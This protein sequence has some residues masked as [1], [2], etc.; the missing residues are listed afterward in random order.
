MY[1]V[2]QR[3]KKI[4]IIILYNLFCLFKINSKKVLIYSPSSDYLS[5]N[6]G[7]IKNNIKN[8]KVKVFYQNK[9]V[10]SLIYNIATS[11]LIITDDYS[12]ILYPLKI[13]KKAEFIQVWHASGVFKKVGFI[14]P[15]ANRNSITHKNYTD[16]IVSSTNIVDDYSEAFGIDKNKIRPLGTIKTDLFFDKGIID[17]MRSTIRKKYNLDNKVVILYAPTFRGNG[18]K[19]AYNNNIL[20]LDN[21][22][23]ILDKNYVILFR[24]HPF[25]KDKMHF[26]SSRI[27]DISKEKYIDY[28]LPSIDILITDYSSIIFDTILLHKPVVFY[29]P[30]LKEY[31]KNRGF[32]YDFKEYNYGK[33]TVTLNELVKAIKERN[34]DEFKLKKIYEKHLNMCDGKSLERF[35]KMYLE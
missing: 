25:V 33:I 13:R 17:K 18:R 10:F 11:K 21:L 15:T 5:L 22:I 30:D 16:V 20:N 29:V 1:K 8:R 19:S 23:D 9:K 34:I 32:Y 3:I 31:E 28:I 12:P 7:I 14:R 6:L 26:N 24:N 35:I 27:I 2:L 4:F